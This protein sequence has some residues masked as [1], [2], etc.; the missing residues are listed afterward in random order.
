MNYIPIKFFLKKGN[1]EF[2][3]NRDTLLYIKLI[4]KNTD[5]LYSKG[6][7]IQYLITTYNRQGSEKEYIMCMCT[8]RETYNQITL[9]CI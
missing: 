8:K 6:N 1:D 7:Y 3:I 2:G 4:K 5:I 9:L